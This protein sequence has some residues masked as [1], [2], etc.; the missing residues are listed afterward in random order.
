MKYASLIRG[1]N[2]SGKNI[3]KMAELRA[4]L[5][6]V[7]L[8]EV[9]TYIQSGNVICSS[10]KDEKEISQLIKKILKNSFDVEAPV[11]IINPNYLK[12]V[13]HANPYK[14]EDPKKVAIGF[15]NKTAEMVALPGIKNEQLAL[16]E[17]CIYL[18]Y[19]DGMGKSKI[20]NTLIE[21]KMGVVST[22]RNL[23]TCEKVL[24]YLI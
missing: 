18:Y 8:E 15:L 16:G 14:S 10:N 5:E 23:N 12:E 19:P 6:Q 7:G 13:M 17:K 1:I 22:M 9:K 21:K 4:A 24:D 20:S 11:V 2:V 3:V